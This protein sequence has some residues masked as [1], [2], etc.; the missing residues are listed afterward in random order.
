MFWLAFIFE[1]NLKNAINCL[2]FFFRALDDICE[3]IKE[4]QFYKSNIF[5]VSEEHSSKIVDNGDSN[6]S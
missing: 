3:S 4:L 1:E 5:K 2:V 6:N